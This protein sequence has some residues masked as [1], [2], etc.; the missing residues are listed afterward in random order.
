[1]ISLPIFSPL[2]LLLLP[3]LLCG[4]NM[5]FF[6]KEYY[7]FRFVW[8]TVDSLS[9]SWCSTS[10][11]SSETSEDRNLHFSVSPKKLKKKVSWSDHLEQY[12]ETCSSDTFSDDSLSPASS[13]G[14]DS[15]HDPYAKYHEI[16]PGAHA[17]LK[18]SP[19]N[20]EKAKTKT[21][22]KCTKRMKEEQA[23][24]LNIWE[25]SWWYGRL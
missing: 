1:M 11:L 3:L 14:H 22:S 9:S 8:Y 4:P 16:S 25:L 15:E 19:T 7:F 6:F 12:F 5:T 20:A 2:V 23:G 21:R 18:P 17:F 13:V 24:V 10:S